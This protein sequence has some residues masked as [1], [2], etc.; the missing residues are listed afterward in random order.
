MLAQQWYLNYF[1]IALEVA[2]EVDMSHCKA[3][4]NAALSILP[5]INPYAE[6]EYDFGTHQAASVS[7]VRLMDL[8]SEYKLGALKLGRAIL[9]AK[10]DARCLQ[11]GM[12]MQEDYNSHVGSDLP[13]AEE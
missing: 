6:M 4:S 1:V 9:D 12:T 2:N 8:A 5:R 3:L 7:L 11:P 10:P 13:A